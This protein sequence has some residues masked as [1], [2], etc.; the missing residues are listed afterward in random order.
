M[1]YKAVMCLKTYSARKFKIIS[2]I[3]E[4]SLILKFIK[5]KIFN[6][7]M[8]VRNLKKRQTISEFSIMYCKL[9]LDHIVFIPRLFTAFDMLLCTDSNIQT[10]CF[11]IPCTLTSVSHMQK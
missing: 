5:M 7:I 6:V 9:S 1:S 10:S 8:L 2:K 3:I 11:Q 4:F